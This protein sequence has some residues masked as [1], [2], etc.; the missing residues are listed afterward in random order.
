MKN[1]KNQI[2]IFLLLIAILTSIIFAVVITYSKA[3][4]VV[5]VCVDLFVILFTVYLFWLIQ[6]LNK[7]L[8]Y[9]PKNQETIKSSVSSNPKQKLLCPK[10]HHPYD[11]EI[12]FV[13]GYDRN[14]NNA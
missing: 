6:K 2:L 7:K 5:K 8:I 14:E 1:L 3:F 9:I 13:C 12:C 10:C 4:W 11:G